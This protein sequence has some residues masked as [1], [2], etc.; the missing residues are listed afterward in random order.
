MDIV[1]QVSLATIH[2]VKPIYFLTIAYPLDR[3]QIEPFDSITVSSLPDHD[4][5]CV[6]VHAAYQGYT[7]EQE[8][9]F[10]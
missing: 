1:A 9:V 3:V 2:L 6:M 7:S 5:G 8:V 4:Q 10:P